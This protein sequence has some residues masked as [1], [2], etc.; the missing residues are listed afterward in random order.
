M[1]KRLFIS[2]LLLSVVIAC[3]KEIDIDLNSTDPKLVIEA[4]LDDSGKGAWVKLSKTVNFSDTFGPPIQSGALVVLVR[5]A[6]NSRDTLQ[7]L[8]DSAYVLPA[9]VPV[10]GEQYAFE[11]THQG[12]FYRALARMPQPVNLD[13]LVIEPT[14][15]PGGLPS[16]P[17]NRRNALLYAYY[18]DPAGERN[19]YQLQA[20][21]NDTATTNLFLYNDE[22]NSG[23]QQI[24]PVFVQTTINGR[25]RVEL[26]HI[27][28]AVFRYLTNLNTNIGQGSASP[29]NPIS[30]F[31]G[32]AMGYFKLYAN[33]SAVFQLVEPATP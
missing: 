32:G 26:H 27:E 33:R 19:Y 21:Q 28:G 20:F 4:L 30:N 9:Y 7:Q 25:I 11:I 13:S 23:M 3:E 16:F 17:P 31:S 6:D 5:L 8:L 15:G 18:S 1:M 24:S 29:A 2:L 10:Y 12:D 22:I 14:F